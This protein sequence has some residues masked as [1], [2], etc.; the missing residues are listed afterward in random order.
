[1]AEALH[2]QRFISAA[3]FSIAAGAVHAAAA[4]AHGRV[5]L[6]GPLIGLTAVAQL[7][8]GLFILVNPTYL[9]MLAG[10]VINGVAFLAWAMSRTIG[11]PWRGPQARSSRSG[12]RT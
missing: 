11:L 12:F 8:W 4:G 5:G 1:M 6:L 2:H 7:T 3:A 10:V 9:G